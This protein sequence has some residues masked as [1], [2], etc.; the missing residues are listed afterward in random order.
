M[1]AYDYMDNAVPGLKYGLGG[2]IEGGWVVAEANGI[3]FGKPVF[4]Y[5]G[6]EKKA[7][8]FYNDVGKIVFDADFVANNVITITVNGEDAADVTYDTS[9]DNTMDLLVAAVS[10]LTGVECALDPADTDNRTLLIRVKGATAA[11]AEA[12]TGGAGQATGTVTYGSGQVFVGVAMFV[13]KASS[14]DVSSN[15]GYEQYDMVNVVA[16]GELWVRAK[17]VVEANNE[18]YIDNS[19]ADIGEFS[20]AGVEVSARYRSNAAD[21]GLARLRVDG[22]KEMTYASSF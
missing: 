4:G 14:L 13:Q 5:V 15:Q 17:A 7:Y 18:A 19:G 3:G 9:H 6:D 1:G 16:D 22:Q 12:V 21:E 2:R 8:S 10:A 20:N 11:V